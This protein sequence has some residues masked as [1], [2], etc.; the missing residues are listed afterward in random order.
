M[1]E[2]VDRR[3]YLRCDVVG[4]VNKIHLIAIQCFVEFVLTSSFQQHPCVLRPPA[5]SCAALRMR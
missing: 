3:S 1:K 5:L 4:V 2:Q